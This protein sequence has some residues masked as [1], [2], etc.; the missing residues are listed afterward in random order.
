M[1]Q[2][3]RWLH[4]TTSIIFISPQKAPLLASIQIPWYFLGI[5]DLE[6]RLLQDWLTT[7]PCQE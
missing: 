4:S 5:R 2:D 6:E 1:S 3:H 7:L